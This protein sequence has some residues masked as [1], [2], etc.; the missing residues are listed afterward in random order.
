MASVAET[1][2]ATA[3]A[4]PSAVPSPVARESSTR[5]RFA[6]LESLAVIKDQLVLGVK[7]ATVHVPTALVVAYSS[8]QIQRAALKC[9][10]L[11]GVLLLG[12]LVFYHLVVKQLLALLFAWTLPEPAVAGEDPL[13]GSTAF[14]VVD[15]AV[16]IL[17]HV[18]WVY[19]VY[20][21]SFVLNSMWYT[22]IA[23]RSLDIRQAQL[24]TLGRGNADAPP[25]SP[26][27]RKKWTQNIVDE[28]YRG[29]LSV[30]HLSVAMVAY[31]APALGPVLSFALTSWMYAM[32]SFEYKWASQGWSLEAR[33]RHMEERWPYYLGF[34]LPTTA[35]TFYGNPIV[36]G[37][38]F[39]LLFP[40]YIITATMTTP[41]P[42]GGRAPV[43]V[44]GT[45]SL[46]LGEI[47]N[48]P[49][50][51]RAYVA[52]PRLPIF[53]A[54]NFACKLVLRSVSSQQEKRGKSPAPAA[55]RK[56]KVEE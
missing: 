6:P 5:A 13:A 23:R 14:A 37:A 40:L 2:A 3:A 10:L 48:P 21:L 11:N 24:R 9:F 43:L 7:D 45:R 51:E 26:R 50:V 55:D 28:L 46:N 41:P 47:G 20:A 31:F 54:A 49:N 12:S 39:A 29:L 30:V 53:S 17:Y 15:T 56:A 44:A 42:A 8:T 38:V 27:V 22:D 34:G 52:V 19:P 33:L 35:L 18:F 36:T 16:H 1:S 25:A 4:I 32:Y